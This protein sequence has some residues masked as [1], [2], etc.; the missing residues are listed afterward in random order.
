MSS[1]IQSVCPSLRFPGFWGA[2][3]LKKLGDCLRYQ[4]PTKYLVTDTNYND[5]YKTPVLTAGKTFVL[6]YT[7]EQHGIFHE[8]L[9][10]VI[11][12]DFTTASKF[13]EFPFKAKSSAM[14]ILH[15]ENGYNIKFMYAALQKICYE[16]GSHERHW[17]SKF[18][19][20]QIS[21][22]SKEEQQKIADCLSS[23]D[24]LIET[25]S[26]KL[27]LLKA[28]KKALMQQLFPARGGA[29]RLRFP[30]FRSLGPWKEKTM[31]DICS[32]NPSKTIRRSDEQVSFIPMAFVSEEGRIE[33]SEMR[34]YSEVSKG[35]TSFVDKDVIV[36]KITPCFENGKAALVDNL[37]GGAGYGSTEFHVFRAKEECCPE[38]LFFQLYRDKIRKEGI[39]SM[40]GNAGQRRVPAVFFKSLSFHLA[41][42]AEQQKIVNFLTS[43]DD[44]ISAKTQKL[45]CHK[46]HKKSLMQQLFPTPHAG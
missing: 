18:A 29:P 13:V 41:T 33:K 36:A 23:L 31:D 28:H 45:E 40:V 8:G 25:Q 42:S 32:I 16:V 24:D 34:L 44:L 17:I 10:V 35:Y 19:P 1:E 15:A 2:W 22:P 43:I 3:E 14:K 27:E 21:V 9:P 39:M 7:N 46:I 4:Q 38:F 11:F 20:M 26:Q 5:A 12:D 30:E 6:G 37:E